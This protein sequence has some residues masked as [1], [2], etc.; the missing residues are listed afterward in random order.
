MIVNKY[1][2]IIAHI[3]CSYR[4]KSWKQI[5]KLNHKRLNKYS[6]S[7]MGELGFRISSVRY[8]KFGQGYN[9]VQFNKSKF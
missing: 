7:Y 9:F 5:N 8:Q 3:H 4:G 6:Y 2:M 1:Y